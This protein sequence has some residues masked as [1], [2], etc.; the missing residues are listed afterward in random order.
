MAFFSCVLTGALLGVLYIFPH[1][2]AEAAREGLQAWAFSLVPSLGPAMALCL[3]LCTHLPGRRSLQLLSA[4]LCG[5]PGGARL[6][7]ENVYD[8]KSALH[9]AALTGVI[10]PLFFLSAV[11]QWMQNEKAAVLLYFCHLCGA[12]L[13]ALCIPGQPAQPAVS[14]PLTLPRCIQQAVNALLQIGYYVMLGFVSARMIGCVFPH[15]PPFCSIL[16]QSFAE[17]TGGTKQMIASCFPLPLLCSVISFGGLSILMQ[18]H[19]YWKEKGVSLLHLAGIRLLHG[20][21]SGILC[22]FLQNLPFIG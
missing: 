16:L 21:L 10:S 8:T 1:P 3:Y 17:V 20:F 12:C 11:S 14:T 4:L 9:D 13:S 15:L 18:N 7:Q 22:F 5:S 2:A 19:A 6:M